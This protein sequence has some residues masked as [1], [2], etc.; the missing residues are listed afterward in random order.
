LCPAAR[1]EERAIVGLQETNPGLDIAG[2]AKVAID[3][4]LGTQEGRR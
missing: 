2:M 1:G 4:K 3:G